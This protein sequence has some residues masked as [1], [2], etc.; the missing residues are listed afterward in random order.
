MKIHCLCDFTLSIIIVTV[1]RFD[2][3]SASFYLTNVCF[4]IARCLNLL[5]FNKALY[6]PLVFL[7]RT[8]QKV[9][10]QALEHKR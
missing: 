1:N 3:F 9:N 5:H 4:R 2:C 8:V 7:L 10:N 6:R